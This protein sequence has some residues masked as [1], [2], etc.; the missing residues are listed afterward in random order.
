M[1]GAAGLGLSVRA[2]QPRVDFDLVIEAV[3]NSGAWQENAAHKFIYQPTV[4]PGWA[5]YRHG[6]WRYTDYGW[7]WQGADRGSWA[8]DHYG[9]WTKRGTVSGG[10]AWVPGGVWLPSAVEWLRSGDYLGWRASKLDRFSNALEPENIR[11]GDPSEWNF[12]LAEKIREPLTVTD[13]APPDQTKDLLVSARPADHVFTSY[14][15]IE[16]PGPDPSILKDA[17]GRAPAIPNISDLSAPDAEPD[18]KAGATE[19]RLYLYRPKFYQ[20]EDGIFRRVDLFL[21]PQART[22]QAAEL[23]QLAKPTPA[24]LK[25]QAEALQRQE[26]LLEKQRQ[27]EAELY[28]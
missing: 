26:E 12:T 19:S 27:H 10:W 16:R 7:T 18:Q 13:F 15:E 6:Q 23:G 9:Y 21:R 5:P 14:R 8:T 3:K 11:Y 22:Q 1:V 17:D 24:D 28:R 4:P 2:E 20:D 25:K